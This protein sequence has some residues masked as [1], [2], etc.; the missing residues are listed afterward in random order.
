MAVG[1]PPI[2]HLVVRVLEFEFGP[3]VLL[4]AHTGRVN[5]NQGFSAPKHD[6]ESHNP[7]Q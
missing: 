1:C 3:S 5:T 7:V 6:L 2:R 4:S